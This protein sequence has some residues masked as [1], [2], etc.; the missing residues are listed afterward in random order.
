MYSYGQDPETNAFQ[1]L[2]RKKGFGTVAMKTARGL[3]RMRQDS[4]FMSSLPEGTAPH[5]ALVRWLTTATEIGAAVIRVRNLDE[6]AETFSGAGKSLTQGDARA[7]EMLTARA[8][9]TACRLCTACQPHCPR[10]VPVAE[11]LRFE[12]YALD[13]GDWGKARVLYAGLDRKADACARCGTCL[14]HCPQG[15]PIPERIAAVHTLLSPV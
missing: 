11:I 10:N 4:D 14:S 1:S 6:F 2:A 5:N 7:I 8:D 12:R 13:D 9:E 3:G 15:L